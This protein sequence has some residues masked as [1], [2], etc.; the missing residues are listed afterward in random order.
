M[1][2]AA[3]RWMGWQDCTHCGARG[4]KLF[5]ANR[6][7]DATPRLVRG[8]AAA[9][10]EPESTVGPGAYQDNDPNVVYVSA[11]TTANHSSASGG[12]YAY[13]SITN[14]KAKLTV[15]GAGSIKVRTIRGPNRGIA[16]VLVDGNKIG[17]LNAYHNSLEFNYTAEYALPDAGTHSFALKVTTNKDP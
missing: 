2:G 11:W 1:N 9:E 14:A 8:Q 16:E 13:S 3:W 17:E 12:T 5:Y 15:T 6:N 7:T 4:A 10:L